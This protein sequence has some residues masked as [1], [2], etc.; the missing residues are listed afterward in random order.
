MVRA[1][2][3]RASRPKM[4]RSQST[5]SVICG[6]WTLTMTCCPPRR[7]A[8]WAWAMKPAAT[9]SQS[10]SAKASATGRPI[11][12]STSART[13]S[14]SAGATCSCRRVSSRARPG[15]TISGRV[16]SI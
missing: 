2:I 12:S 15:E 6:R 7:T 11:S 8:R 5:A 14:G 9:G 16:D 13:A 1:S 4:D 3:M 10:N